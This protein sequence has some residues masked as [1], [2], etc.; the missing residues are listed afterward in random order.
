MEEYYF[1]AP[2][3]NSR[4]LCVGPVTRNE[5]A[6]TD[7]PF[8]DSLG[9][10]LYVSDSKNPDATEVLA[11]FVSE[12]AAQRMSAMLKCLN[13]KM[14]TPTVSANHSPYRFAP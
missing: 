6:A 3:S 9:Y 4:S 13:P 14:T 11:R 1:D 10:Y 7:V 5:A 12:E 8:C 2:L